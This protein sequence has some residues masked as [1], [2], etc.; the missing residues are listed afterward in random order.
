MRATMM[1]A[2]GATV[3]ALACLAV[4]GC[5]STSRGPYQTLSESDRNTLEAEQLTREAVDLM[6][7][8][9]E[10]AEQLLRDAL[11]AD[12]FHGPAHNNLGVLFLGRGELYEAAS[13][14]EWAGKLM[15]GHPDP[16]MNLALTLERAGRVDE[17]LAAYDTALEVYPNHL[18]TVQALCRCQIRHGRADDRTREL[19]NEISLRGEDERWRTWAQR[20]LVERK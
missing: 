19:L 10:Q 13:E 11:T 20:M 5:S 16:R 1:S 15:P 7:D 12:V 8:D 2:V 6:R 3:V 4:S 17:A 9:P 18:P 14:F